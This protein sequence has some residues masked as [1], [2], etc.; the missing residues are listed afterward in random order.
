MLFQLGN[1][2][3]DKAFAPDSITRSD[4]TTYAEHALMGQKPRLQPTAN[5]LEEIDLPIKLR[6]EIVNVTGTILTLKNSKDNFEVLPLLMG[7]GRYLGDY[8]I[9]KIDEVQSVT[10]ADGTLVEASINISLKEFVIPDK[11]QQQQNTARKQAF[12]AGDKKPVRQLSIQK[13]TAPN[14]AA[15]EL[16]AVYSNNTTADAAIRQYPNNP[17]GQNL[18]SQKIESALNHAK[19]A[20]GNAT[21][22][23][24]GLPI[25]AN[26][27]DILAKIQQVQS[28]IGQFSFPVTD[29]AVLASNNLNLQA[30]VKA[31]KISA[32]TLINLVIT[33]AA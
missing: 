8:V 32:T 17:T 4:E 13:R 14:I 22:I 1:M 3:F 27:A 33:R 29:Q 20:L 19:T 28:A 25:P 7:T 6:A 26:K 11:L 16:G 18:L 12:A 5:N 2:V 24:N 31:L 10:L 23:L 15:K 9:T 30:Q 21:D